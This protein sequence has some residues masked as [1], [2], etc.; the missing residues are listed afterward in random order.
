MNIWLIFVIFLI[1]YIFI[2]I[3]SYRLGKNK[4]KNDIFN[5]QDIVYEYIKDQNDLS[6]LGLVYDINSPTH[7]HIK[8]TPNPHNSKFD[9][10][11]ELKNSLIKELKS[12]NNMSDYTR[13]FIS[14]Q[15]DILND[16]TETH[17]K[18]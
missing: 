14:G 7:K 16:L 17:K 3:W 10:L 6:F 13:G 2:S 5:C 15:I 11:L 9:S 18:L 4:A 8:D 1:I 12:N